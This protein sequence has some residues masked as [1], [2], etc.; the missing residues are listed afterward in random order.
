[1]SAA[2]AAASTDPLQ[3]A[4]WLTVRASGIIALAALTLTVWLGLASAGGLLQRRPQL[5]GTVSIVH[6]MLALAALGALAVHGVAL[7]FDGWLKPSVL[8]LLVP[9][10]M[11]HAPLWTGLGQL[12]GYAVLLLGPSFYLRKRIGPKRWRSLHRFTVVAFLMAVGHAIGSGTDSGSAWLLL[13]LLGGT[14]VAL[15][16]LAIRSARG[17]GAAPTRRG[18]ATARV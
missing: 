4:A 9:F 2:L 17:G 16:L 12:A 18:R 3:Y 13:P 5:R 7:L 10:A 14:T 11:P 8:Q 1:M 6:E 15:A